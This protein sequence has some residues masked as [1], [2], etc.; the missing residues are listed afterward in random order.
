MNNIFKYF[1]D[2]GMKYE[3]GMLFTSD[4]MSPVKNLGNTEILIFDLEKDVICELL[5]LNRNDYGKYFIEY[6]DNKSIIK[7]EVIDGYKIYIDN[8]C[9]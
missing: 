4:Y 1:L 7:K 2:I 5:D 8:Q 3:Y 9:L 6:Y